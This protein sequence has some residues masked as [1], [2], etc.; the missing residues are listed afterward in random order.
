M[1]LSSELDTH[2]APHGASV[3][4]SRRSIV[5]GIIAGLMLFGAYTAIVAGASG[6]FSHYLDL[7]GADWYYI[8]P[9]MA[10]FGIQF[11]LMSELRRRHRLHA[12]EAGIG[13]TGAGASTVGM[14]ACCAHHIVDLAP[15]LG[16]SA[17]A[18]FLT[19]WKVPLIGVGLAI[20]GV[21]IAVGV[22]NL[23]R[24]RSV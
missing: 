20:N 4:S 12:L 10:A 14:V 16:A 6:S 5:H 22:R 21:G 19:T 3:R 9:L 13:A 17:A 8:A 15:F 1:S 24:L 18:T 7:A 23:R 2:T 11:G